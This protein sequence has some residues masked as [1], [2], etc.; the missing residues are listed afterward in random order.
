MVIGSGAVRKGGQRCI[1]VSELG[2][3]ELMVPF[4]K[5]GNRGETVRGRREGR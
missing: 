4:S 5:V 1:Q 2:E 3:K